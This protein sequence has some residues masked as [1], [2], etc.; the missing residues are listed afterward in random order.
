MIVKDA[1]KSPEVEAMQDRLRQKQRARLEAQR[2][3]DEDRELEQMFRQRPRVREIIVLEHR[4]EP[5]ISPERQRGIPKVAL[6]VLFVMM[7]I[8]NL[9]ALW[10]GEIPIVIGADMVTMA[11]ALVGGFA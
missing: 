9:V 11:L 6:A 3:A 8:V 5:T 7:I 2:Q 4:N 10:Y 1:G